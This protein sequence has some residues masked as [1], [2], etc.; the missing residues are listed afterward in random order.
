ML[1]TVAPDASLLDRRR[2]VLLG[3]GLPCL[4]HHHE[5]Q[6]LPRREAEALVGRVRTSA[7]HHAREAL[8]SLAAAVSTKISGIALRRYAALPPT[9]AERIAD[10]RAQT[11]ADSAMYR[12]ALADAAKARGWSVHWYDP[13]QV[14]LE[15]ARALKLESVDARFRDLG[16]SIGPPW[17]KDHR[18]AMAAAIAAGQR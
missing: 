7:E 18:L 13:K 4:A 5:A 6:G 16:K 10:Y 3:E 11:F 12:D 9:V 17:Q 14:F 8:E 2:V 1:I 15:A